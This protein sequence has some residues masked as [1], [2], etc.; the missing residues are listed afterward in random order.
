MVKSEN[1]SPLKGRR[2]VKYNA[3]VYSQLNIDSHSWFTFFFSCILAKKK[4]IMLSC[5]ARICPLRII[6]QI[7]PWEVLENQVVLCRWSSAYLGTEKISNGLT[8]LQNNIKT[9]PKLR[10]IADNNAKW[11]DFAREHCLIYSSTI[12]TQKPSLRSHMFQYNFPTQVV[13]NNHREK[14]RARF[15]D[16]GPENRWN[17]NSSTRMMGNFQSKLSRSRFL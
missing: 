17:W 11:R 3:W 5:T 14:K 2:D 4:N 1:T 9:R 12:G 8:R 7:M 15:C 16:R 13:V 6:E 10:S